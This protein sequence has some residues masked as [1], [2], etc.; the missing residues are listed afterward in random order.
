MN[1]T[2]PSNERFTL[3]FAL[4]KDHNIQMNQFLPHFKQLFDDPI[5][6][7]TNLT[8]LTGTIGPFQF[9]ISYVDH[10]IDQ[11]EIM[12]VAKHNSLFKEGP[13]IAKG[14]KAHAVI[15]IK[16]VGNDVLRYQAFTKLLAA[17]SKSYNC[18]AF[19]LG[20][21]QL[22]YGR[23]MVLDRIETLK[24]GILPVDLWLYVGYVAEEEGILCYSMGME[25]FNRRDIVLQATMHTPKQM[26]DTLL[27]YAYYC[28][29]AHRSLTPNQYL[30]V[31]EGL[32]YEP[33][34]SPLLSRDVDSLRYAFEENFGRM[35][36]EGL[37]E[38]TI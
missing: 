2:S 10:P 36:V 37:D 38:R 22:M 4:Y 11:E 29:L 25:E 32:I 24:E 16:G 15:A 35:N 9:V 13:T 8:E 6:V 23:T 20:R 5:E 26:H 33:T 18:V 31:D 19:Y 34:F 14:H 1:T 17:L 7:K 30:E 3:G 28:L 12:R 27:N 21:Q